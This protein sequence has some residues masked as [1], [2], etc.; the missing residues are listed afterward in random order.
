MTPDPL[1]LDAIR[2]FITVFASIMLMLMS[3]GMIAFLLIVFWSRRQDC[4]RLPHAEVEKLHRQMPRGRNPD[5]NVQRNAE[6]MRRA[7]ETGLYR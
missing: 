6:L 3:G 5:I 2:C 7:K 4:K 1:T